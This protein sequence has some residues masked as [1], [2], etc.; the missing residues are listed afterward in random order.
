MEDTLWRQ[1][2]H[3]LEVPFRISNVPKDI[4][5]GWSRFEIKAPNLNSDYFLPPSRAIRL[6]EVLFRQPL[7]SQ[8]RLLEHAEMVKEAERAQS[9]FFL[10]KTQ[11]LKKSGKNKFNQDGQREALADEVR[12]LAESPDKFEEIMN[13]YKK[14][15]ER[16]QRETEDHIEEDHDS[17]TTGPAPAQGSRLLRQSLLASA[18]IRNSVSSKLNYILNEVSYIELC[19]SCFFSTRLTRLGSST[20]CNREIPHL[21]QPT[22]GI[23]PRS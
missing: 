14:A 6:R 12:K 3:S 22:F 8:L 9:M 4:R 19:A 16:L 15:E 20:F 18:R 21:F 5:D 1:M 10:A 23:G 11:R 13:E 2:Q 17:N 7:I